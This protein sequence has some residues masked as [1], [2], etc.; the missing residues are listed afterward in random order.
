MVFNI[1]IVQL[2]IKPFSWYCMV[3]SIKNPLIIPILKILQQ[4]ETALGEYELI[5]QLKPQLDHCI[6]QNQSQQLALFQTHFLVMN[7]LYQL[8][9][10][11]LEEAVYLSISPL[12]IELQSI[13]TGV[14]H[15]LQS[16]HSDGPLA[17]YYLNWTHFNDTDD[18]Q[19]SDLLKGFWQHFLAQDQHSQALAVLELEP[20]AAWSAVQASYRRL[21][22]LKHPDRGGNAAE[23][24][25]VREAYEVLLRV[26][27][28]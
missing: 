17:D 25:A 23:F 5:N 10:Q 27:G 21:V 20:G 18:E 16:A 6:D 26:Y 14:G 3:S 24:M 2:F 13:Q 15:A 7:A 19:V 12:A 28:E 11:L 4:A 8:Q 9:Q 1:A 22:A